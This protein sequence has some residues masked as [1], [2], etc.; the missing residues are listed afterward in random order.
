MT[1]DAVDKYDHDKIVF[2]ARHKIAIMICFSL[3][4]ALLL[5]VFMMSYHKVS[6][7]KV[8]EN[9]HEEDEDYWMDEEDIID[10]FEDY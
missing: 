2:S 4:A 9:E 10:D 7:E 5:G 1:S 8:D 3:S 6:Q